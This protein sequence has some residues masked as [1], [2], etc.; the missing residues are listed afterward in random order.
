MGEGGE[1][2]LLDIENSLLGL[3]CIYRPHLVH[4]RKVHTPE[5]VDA[6]CLGHTLYEMS[7][8]RILTTPTCDTMP[9]DCSPLLCKFFTT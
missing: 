4:L 9:L 2:R 7:L 1:V 6:Y 3:P 8:G 5:S